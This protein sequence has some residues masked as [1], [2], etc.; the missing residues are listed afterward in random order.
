MAATNVRFPDDLKSEAQV[1]AGTLG[2]SFN[3]LLA[4]ALREYLDQRTPRASGDVLAAASAIDPKF[5][6]VRWDLF[7][8]TPGKNCLCGST[9]PFSECHGRGVPV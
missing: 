3:G 6:R 5:G 1:Y 2:L 8:G 7:P 9:R 4:V